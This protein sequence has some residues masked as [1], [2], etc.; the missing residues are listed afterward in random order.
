[1]KNR[2]LFPALVLLLVAMILAVTGYMI[3]ESGN[4]AKPRQI[5]VIIENSNDNR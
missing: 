4:T 5:Q 2:R 1:M 3:W